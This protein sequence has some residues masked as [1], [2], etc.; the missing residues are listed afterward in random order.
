L[1]GVSFSQST[2]GA[3]DDALQSLAAIE[4]DA[5][6]AARASDLF[7]D[8]IGPK[9][10]QALQ[11]GIGELDR[12]RQT[13]HELGIVLDEEL[14]ARAEQTADQFDV[15]GRVM[16]TGFQKLVL[17]NAQTVLT[18]ANAFM[19]V[20]QWAFGAAEKVVDFTRALGEMAGG[21]KGFGA[22][23]DVLEAQIN[24]LVR[25]R[26]RRGPVNSP[27]YQAGEA[28]IARL[29]QRQLDVMTSGRNV[30]R[31]SPTSPNVTLTGGSSGGGIGT[32]G[33]LNDGQR[34]SPEIRAF[35]DQL[36]R[37]EKLT[38]S[39]RTEVEQ[40]VEAWREASNLFAAG[41]ID[42]QTLERVRDSLLQPIEVTAK[43]M[44]EILEDVRGEWENVGKSMGMSLQDT[45]AGAMLGIETNWKDMIKRMIAQAVASKILGAIGAATAGGPVGAFMGFLGFG[46]GRA[47]GGPLEPGKWHI[48]GEKGPE[49]IW[50]GGPGAFAMGYP[51]GGGGDINIYQ[52]NSFNGG[53]PR[54]MSAAIAA[55][56]AK[57]KNEIKSEILYRQ[58]R[59]QW[60]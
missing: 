19:S 11:G 47:Q 32:G 33:G 8:K 57:L 10:A 50:G 34:L 15:L 29:Q 52:T 13:A 3:L 40:Q 44:P 48:A 42:E 53:D 30:P 28:E 46:G 20:A 45:L 12:M 35:V 9:L 37:G 56:N 59:G 55:N 16:G 18:L 21:A 14:V 17:D 36:E 26:S 58:R 5:V 2:E 60:G 38:E 49:P 4:N 22:E 54:E 39:M 6:R 25:G 7:G 41:A 1:L 24:A 31:G 23:A 27:S 43:R 51:G